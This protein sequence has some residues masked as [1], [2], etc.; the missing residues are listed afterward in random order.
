M[1][2]RTLIA[3][4][5]R[6][7]SGGKTLIGGTGREV[8]GG[9][10][11]IGGTGREISFASEFVLYDASLGGFQA[12]TVTPMI[13]YTLNNGATHETASKASSSLSTQID[14]CTRLTSGGIVLGY[15]TWTT[16]GITAQAWGRIHISDSALFSKYKSYEIVSSGAPI[17][18]TNFDGQQILF[19]LNVSQTAS[20]TITKITLYP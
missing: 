18:K 14:Q 1:S 11:L 2:H 19:W 16:A 20:A 7:V 5:S 9:K 13:T 3:G 15:T 17:V 12:G 6:E 10:T 4:T 8:S